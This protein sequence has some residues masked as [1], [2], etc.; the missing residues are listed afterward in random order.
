VIAMHDSMNPEVRRGMDAVD[1]AAWPKVRFVHLD[2]VAGYVFNA[3]LDGELWGGLAVVV[4]DDGNPRAATEPAHTPLYR[5]THPLVIAGLDAE[6]MRHA[7]HVVETSKSWR[8]TAP[9]RALARR[10]RG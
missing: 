10:M 9:L 2:A 1:F 7:L 6:R 3:P 8:L 5:P 4:V